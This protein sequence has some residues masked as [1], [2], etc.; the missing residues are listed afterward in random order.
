M[1]TYS[2]N[3]I[4]LCTSIDDDVKS[5]AVDFELRL[6]PTWERKGHVTT[7]FANIVDRC[8][9]IL[10]SRYR[11]IEEVLKVVRIEFRLTDSSLRPRITYSS[12][13]PIFIG[14]AQLFR[15]YLLRKNAE[16]IICGTGRVENNGDIS[17][18]ENLIIKLRAF[19]KALKSN[20]FVGEYFL[21]TPQDFKNVWEVLDLVKQGSKGRPIVKN[22]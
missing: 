15:T 3:I 2:Q 18:V 13:L 14:L 17:P 6:I 5:Y 10:S 19:E 8:V 7:E 22:R 1:A 21:A 16:I 20:L 9:K 11:E 12:T 4:L